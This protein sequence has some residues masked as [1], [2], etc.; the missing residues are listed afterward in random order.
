MRW[1]ASLILIWALGCEV[2]GSSTDDSIDAHLTTDTLRG[3]AHSAGPLVDGTSW[4]IAQADEDL[5]AEPGSQFAPCD[6]DSY[7]E[8]YGGVEVSTGR[9]DHVSLI[10]PLR[11]ALRS[12]DPLRVVGWHSNLFSPE[13]MPATGRIAL[14]IGPQLV[15]ESSVHIPADAA[16]WDARFESPVTAPI[17]T[18]V[19]LHVRNH[20]ANTWN[21]LSFEREE[22]P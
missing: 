4:R 18:P 15:W 5:F 22:S 16:T 9:C 19:S 1:G 7:R 17:G 11:L 10:Q 3:D 8:E 12:G 6:E 13:L 20:G 14:A 2:H 21:I